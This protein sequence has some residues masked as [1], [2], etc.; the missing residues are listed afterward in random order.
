MRW[1]LDS[2]HT[3]VAFSVKHMGLFTVRGQFKKAAGLVVTNEKGVPERVEATIEAA[4]IETGDAQR[5]AHLRSGDFLDVENYPEIRFVSRKVEALGEGRYRILG[6]LTIRGT[7]REVALEAE[8]S[9][10]VK[11]PW[12]NTRIGAS[13]SGT[14]N[15]KDFGLTWNQVLEFGAL[16]VG[17]E[18]R[19]TVDVEAVAVPEPA[20][21]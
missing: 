10:P 21:V 4:S 14:L 15:R 12:G 11:D 9:P 19:F 13:A 1:N 18:V 3:N 20:A 17:E 16:L 5:D 8:V 6:D 7:T 2:S